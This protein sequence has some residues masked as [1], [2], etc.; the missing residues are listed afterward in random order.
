MKRSDITELF[1]EATPEQ[2]QKIM[3]LNGSDINSAKSGQAELQRQ[4]TEAKEALTAAKE[5][6]AKAVSAEDLKK[7]TDRAAALETELNELKAGNQIRDIRDAVSKEKG[8][9]ANLLTG[10]TEEAC[11]TQ[12]DAIL[13][14]AKP[15]GYPSVPDGGEPT[16]SGGGST[17][18]QFAAW[19]GSALT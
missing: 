6:A 13:A 2:I 9:P 19:A 16:G 14:F 18:D 1:P 12:A 15:G 11:R 8:L 4:L 5:A 3:D 10:D 17:R 7:A